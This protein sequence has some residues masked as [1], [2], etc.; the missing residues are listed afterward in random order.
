MT[1]LCRLYGTRRD[2]YGLRLR[3]CVRAC[4]N[5]CAAHDWNRNGE[6]ERKR[7]DESGQREW[8]EWQ[9]CLR[10][11][12]KALKVCAAVATDFA[13]TRRE[14]DEG[15]ITRANTDTPS[16]SSFIRQEWTTHGIGWARF[17]LE[18]PKAC[19]V[20]LQL[21][22]RVRMRNASQLTIES[23]NYRVAIVLGQLPLPLLLFYFYR[24]LVC[25]KRNFLFTC[26]P[27][28][29]WPDTVCVCVC[30]I[31]A[32]GLHILYD[33]I[34]HTFTWIRVGMNNNLLAKLI[35]CNFF[36]LLLRFRLFCRCFIQRLLCWVGAGARW[37]QFQ[38][39]IFN[40]AAA[41]AATMAQP[42]SQ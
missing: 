40:A 39:Y 17:N 3:E 24:A 21:E 5:E 10:I 29:S 6:A 20:M 22:T 34:T 12:Y 25:S 8:T 23:I 9:K 38:R 37:P 36:L 33:A 42:N 32:R 28:L 19:T 14:D 16:S 7:P 18:E 4:V 15:K 26:I 27:S 11:R 2:S 1:A 41:A 13:L 31:E 30:C 35:S